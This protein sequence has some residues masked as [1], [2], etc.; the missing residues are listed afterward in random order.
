[1]TKL[2]EKKRRV[3]IG[4]DDPKLTPHAG[5][6]LIAEVDRVLGVVST[7]DTYV[8][9]IKSRNRGLGAGGLVTST[10]EMML[11][12][13]DFMCDLDNQRA[14]VA[15]RELRAVRQIPSSPTFIALTKQF[16]D[17]VFEGIERANGVLVR[18][19]FNQ[20]DTEHR[21]ALFLERPT[22]DLDPTDVETYGTQKEGVEY[23]YQGQLCGRP[24]PAVWAEAGVVL[25]ADLGSGKSDPRPQAPSL[26]RR[27]VTCLPKGLGRPIIR[28]DSG[29]FDQ[30]VATAALEN[31]S[32]FAI[33]AKRSSATL[34]AARNVPEDAWVQA[35]G[36]DAEVAPCDYVPA[37]WPP[38]THC[39]VRRVRVNADD[40]STDVRSR[41]RKTIDPDQLRLCLDGDADFAYAYS[42]IV[43]NLDWPTVEI[44]RWFRLRALVEERIKDTKLGMALRHLPSGYE[45]TNRTWMWAAIFATNISVWL[46]SLAAID[47]NGRAHGKRL[48][49]ELLNIPARVLHRG[50]SV[51]LRFASTMRSGP[52]LKAWYAMRAFPTFASG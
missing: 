5:L 29:F 27:S 8:G 36:M 41:R 7:I 12:G 23:N 31:G 14:D 11:C 39:V 50:R 37:E 15:G 24:H 35:D 1:V 51:V 9:S 49:R 25:C 47:D 19:W 26:I 18:R 38:G 10:A 43:T 48:R 13:G 16:D 17:D 2:A 45:A 3:V 32:D 22:I 4:R 30:G 46:Q 52:F 20:L 33:V 6:A 28:A 42:F 21:D 44:E 34:R 40:I